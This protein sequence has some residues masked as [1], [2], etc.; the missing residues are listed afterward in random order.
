M[1]VQRAAACQMR[2]PTGDTGPAVFKRM[3]GDWEGYLTSSKY[4]KLASC[5]TD[6]ALRDIRGLLEA[7]LLV[8]NS[9]G[10]R[11]VSYRLADPPRRN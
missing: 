1:L 5:S 7:G 11:S 6:T 10:G 8:R 4:A 2:S 3:L 9:G